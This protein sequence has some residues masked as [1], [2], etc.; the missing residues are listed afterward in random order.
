MNKEKK[1][2]LPFYTNNQ[3]SSILY[4]QLYQNNTHV[5][6]HPHIESVLMFIYLHKVDSHT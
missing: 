5:I 2:S 4:V 3:E 6:S 1:N